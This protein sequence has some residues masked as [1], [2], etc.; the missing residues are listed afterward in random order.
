MSCSGRKLSPTGADAVEPPRVEKCENSL[1]VKC[2]HDNSSSLE[3]V[4]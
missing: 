3:N 2:V 4:L 1:T